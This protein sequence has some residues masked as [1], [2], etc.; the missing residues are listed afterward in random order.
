MGTS[1]CPIREDPEAVYARTLEMIR[2]GAHR[3][4]IVGLID[5]LIVLLVI[6]T[7]ALNASNENN[8]LLLF[9]IPHIASPFV[10]I[11]AWYSR[12][13]SRGIYTFLLV[14][15]ILMLLLDLVG[16]GWRIYRLV[17]C[18]NGDLDIECED[19][20][21]EDIFLAVLVGFFIIIDILYI[22]FT[23]LQRGYITKV[24]RFE[25]EGLVTPQ[26]TDG[27]TNVIP[28]Q[29]APQQY[30]RPSSVPEPNYGT[31][32]YGSMPPSTYQT[33]NR[34]QAVGGGPYSLQTLDEPGEKGVAP[35]YTAPTNGAPVPLSSVPPYSTS[36]SKY[37]SRQNL[38]TPAGNQLVPRPNS[39][40][41]PKKPNLKL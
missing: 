3:I 29:M 26:V 37:R 21:V 7:F 5:L 31:P 22:V 16:F 4:F 32:T 36:S 23:V 15:A 9:N 38:N 8:Y 41:M 24:L 11:L 14:W 12:P 6:V 34:T 10:A 39:S 25:M 13:R 35:P 17:K 28:P 19:F 30:I 1:A 20:F 33:S 2:T 18:D 27:R 40:S